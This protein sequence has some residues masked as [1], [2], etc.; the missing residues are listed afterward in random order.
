M[1]WVG[2]TG[3]LPGGEARRHADDDRLRLARPPCATGSP[4]LG[5]AP[6]RDRRGFPS[7]RGRACRSNMLRWVLSAGPFARGRSHIQ[8]AVRIMRAKLGLAGLLA[9][10]AAACL[11]GVSS[12]GWCGAL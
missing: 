6:I 9:A 3:G 10:L 12:A 7:R 2:V 1:K 11:P 8:K 5:R 4:P